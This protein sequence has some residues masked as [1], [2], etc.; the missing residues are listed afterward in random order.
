METFSEEGYVVVA[1]DLFW[2]SAKFANIGFD[3][4][5]KATKIRKKMDVETALKDIA[6][7][8]I[9]LKALPE[10]VG[11]VGIVGY[12]D[13]GGLL[14]CLSV[15]RGIVDCGVAYSPVGAEKYLTEL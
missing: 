1:P 11:K 4:E 14:A 8:V 3:Q 13:P 5:E 9:Y 12:S 6:T 2:R 7:A 15:S 10:F